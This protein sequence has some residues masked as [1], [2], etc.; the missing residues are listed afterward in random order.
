MFREIG[1]SIRR[2]LKRP[3]LTVTAVVTLALAYGVWY[4]SSI[5]GCP[6]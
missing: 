4:A 2:L 1:Q 5:T 6:P 3:G